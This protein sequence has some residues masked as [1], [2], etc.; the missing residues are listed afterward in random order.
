MPHGVTTNGNKRRS[1]LTHDDPYWSG[2]PEYKYE[3]DEVA[4]KE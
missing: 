3:F 1:Y 2:D 4:A